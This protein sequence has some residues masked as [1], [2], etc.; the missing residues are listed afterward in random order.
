MIGLYHFLLSFYKT[1]LRF[2]DKTKLYRLREK[3]NSGE[4][5][6]PADFV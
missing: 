6:P 3:E 5:I 1:V 2:C 4:Q